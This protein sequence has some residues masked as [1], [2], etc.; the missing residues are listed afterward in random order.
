MRLV[1]DRN[2]FVSGVFFSGPP[3][4]IL[5]AWR[6]GKFKLVVSPDILEEY[7]RT[8]EEL[9]RRFPNV[10]LTPWLE[11]V[12]VKAIV[13]DAPPLAEQVCSDPDDDKFLACAVAGRTK[14]IATGDKALLKASGYRGISVLTPRDF[15]EK[16][17]K[18]RGRQKAARRRGKPRV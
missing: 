6:R 3:Y 16:H 1:V 17:P 11:L 4:D 8:G 7:R 9:A 2:V 13:V 15:V 18:A 14:F 10:A 5:N 12:A